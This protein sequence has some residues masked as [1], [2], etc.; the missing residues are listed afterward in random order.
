MRGQK[1]FA[2][3]DSFAA[4][5]FKG[6]GSKESDFARI[7]KT[8]VKL[9]NDFKHDRGPKTPYEFGV[10]SKE[11]QEHIDYCYSQL[12]FFVKYPIRLVQSIDIDW[13]TNNAI[14]ETLVYEGDHP[15][16]RQEKVDHPKPLTKDILYLELDKNLWVPLYPHVSVQYCQ[17]CKTQET[18]F[19][20]GWEGTKVFLKSF[21]RGHTQ[22]GETNMK[23]VMSN[24]EH[25]ISNNLNG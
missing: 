9:K 21:E 23:Q 6:S 16:L 18:Y 7:T 13:K 20:D 4:L 22:V 19:I 15:G 11:L 3:S 5:W 10:S 17:S 25:W 8:L 1:R 2:I 14:L 24:I 12:S